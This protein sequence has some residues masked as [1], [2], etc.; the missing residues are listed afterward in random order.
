MYATATHLQGM[1]MPP[2]RLQHPE[3]DKASFSARYGTTS[4]G[5]A[6]FLVHQRLAT[7]L[8]NNGVK[9]RAGQVG[10]PG[11]WP[12]KNSNWPAA[13]IKCFRCPVPEKNV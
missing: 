4:V 5:H 8:T 11:N 12:P 10:L 7:A 3:E 6:Q 1:R 13:C 2:G 9:W